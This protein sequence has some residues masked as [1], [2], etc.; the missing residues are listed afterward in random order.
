MVVVGTGSHG[1][2]VLKT[3]Y[4]VVEGRTAGTTK[5]VDDYILEAEEASYLTERDKVGM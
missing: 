1:S 2:A 4:P 5:L 3:A